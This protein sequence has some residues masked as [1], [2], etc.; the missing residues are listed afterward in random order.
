M[1]GAKKFGLLGAGG[2][3]GVE[4]GFDGGE[5]GEARGVGSHWYAEAGAGG[6]RYAVVP[7]GDGAVEGFGEVFAGRG[8][9]AG[10]NYRAFVM[11]GFD[12]GEVGVEAGLGFP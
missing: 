9:C 4:L 2:F 7:E 1:R 12:R 3:L 10:F 6:G 11:F 8:V 5:G